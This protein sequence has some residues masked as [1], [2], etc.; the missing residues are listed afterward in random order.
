MLIA[1]SSFKKAKRRRSQRMCQA[2][3]PPKSTSE[4]EFCARRDLSSWM[5]GKS[6]LIAMAFWPTI[7]STNQASPTA[8][9]TWSTT[10]SSQFDSST[11]VVANKLLRLTIASP[12]VAHLKYLPRGRFLISTMKFVFI[13]ETKSQ[14]LSSS[15]PVRSRTATLL[16]TRRSKVGRE[17]SGSSPRRCMWFNCIESPICYDLQ[18]ERKSCKNTL[19]ISSRKLYNKDELFN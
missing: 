12:I 3:S 8:T 10:W 13:W 19:I 1:N 6:A 18:F 4:K 16:K 15:G 2:L 7:T 5:R 14:T 9:L 11:L 17:P